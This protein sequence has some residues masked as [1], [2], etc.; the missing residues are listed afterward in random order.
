M[1]NL[2][3]QI[4]LLL[5]ESLFLY[6]HIMKN[7]FPLAFVLFMVGSLKSFGQTSVQLHETAKAF[8]LQGDYSNA[9]LVLNRCI[10]QDPR[11]LSMS[12]DLAMS[13]LYKPDLAKAKEIIT[14]LTDRNDA[15]D[16]IFQIAGTI[17]KQ[18]GDN[19][20]S[21]KLYKK[22]L[23]KFPD[24][25]PLYNEL[26]E[27][28]SADKKEEAIKTWEKG[29]EK[30]PSYSRNYYN[31]ARYYFF[32]TDKIRSILYSEIFVNIEPN[33]KR[34]PEMKQL[35]MDSYKKFFAVSDLSKNKNKFEKIYLESLDKFSS[36]TSSGI[37]T[38][39]ISMIRTR[40]VLEWFALPKKLSF[41]LFDYQQQ[42]LQE[43]IFEAYNQWLFGAAEN[44]PAYEN[45]I[46]THTAENNTF[47]AL[48][49]ARIF[50]VP[51][52]QYYW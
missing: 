36:L 50:K 46:S 12:K 1:A 20:E 4:Y 48:Q 25:G 38:E 24:S 41:H 37:N 32:S 13:Y 39:T 35:L 17:Y 29:I 43:G 19:R 42:L 10:E 28:Q 6:L 2:F 21:E 34:T 23:K 44:L 14:S 7:L 26:G 18:S 31:A 40:F 16:Q 15:D 47:S 49:K 30:D 11:N 33:G 45:W 22:G 9:I 8:M 3:E 52:G 5:I 27:L 51:S